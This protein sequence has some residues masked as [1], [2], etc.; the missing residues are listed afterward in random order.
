MKAS[1]PWPMWARDVVLYGY[2]IDNL[3]EDESIVITV[4]SCNENE[5][6]QWPTTLDEYTVRM[7]CKIGGSV[8]KFF[9]RFYIATRFF[10]KP[11][12]TKETHVVMISNVDP[13]FNFI[14]YSLFNEVT[15]KLA[16]RMFWVGSCSLCTI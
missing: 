2:G 11:I 8:K 1:L 15:K 13:K 10:A 7:D 16:H 14:P 5:Q 4:R 6:K 12:S 9:K 3:E